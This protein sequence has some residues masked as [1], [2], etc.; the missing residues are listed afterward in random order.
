MPIAPDFMR[1][2]ELEIVR[3]KPGGPRDGM[4]LYPFS[5]PYLFRAS[6]LTI[7]TCSA[8]LCAQFYSPL[9]SLCR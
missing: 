7:K 3:W 5:S 1:L 6:L 4:I 9:V 8:L 2:V